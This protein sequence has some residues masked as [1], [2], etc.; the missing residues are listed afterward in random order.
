MVP[1]ALGLD[2]FL[3]PPSTNTTE[4]KVKIR[5]KIAK[6]AKQTEFG[7]Q[8]L[9][10]VFVASLAV[11][12]SIKSCVEDKETVSYTSEHLL[13]FFCFFRIIKRIYRFE[14]NSTKV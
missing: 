5:C 13:Y 10:M 1:Y 14:T 9:K 12:L 8:T 2:I 11:T 4:F 6:E 3:R 7:F